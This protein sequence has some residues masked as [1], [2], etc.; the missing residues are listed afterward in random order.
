MLEKE[1]EMRFELD[2]NTGCFNFSGVEIM[3]F[4]DKYPEG[5]QGGVTLIM[6]DK[7]MAQGVD[8]RFEQTPGQWQPIPVCGER[9]IDTDAQSVEVQLHYPNTNA[10]LKGFNPIIYPDLELDYSIIT[11]AIDGGVE[12]IAD[13]KQPLPDS[14][15]GKA[16]LNLEMVPI[17]FMGKCWIMD[18]KEG[19]FPTQPNGPALGL[20]ANFD[21]AGIYQSNIGKADPDKLV[22]YRKE[23]S[24]MVADDLIGAPYA[25]GYNF[26]AIPE[27]QEHSFSVESDTELKL[28]DGRF[29]HN[30]GWFV[31]SS[32]LPTGTTG[33][34]ISWKLYPNLTVPH[35]YKPVVAVSNVGYHPKQTKYAIVELDKRQA[36]QAACLYK[37][38]RTG[39]HPV[40]VLENSAVQD[41]LRYK[42]ARFDFTDI[43]EP[44]MYM[45]EYEGSKSNL[46]RIASDVYDRGVWQPVLE[47]FLPVQMCHMKVSEKYRVWHGL[48]HSDDALMAPVNYNHYDGYVQGPDTLTSFKP[49]EHV[50]GL[51]AGGWHDAGDYDLRIESQSGEVYKLALALEAFNVYYD[52]STID[53][54]NHTVEIHQ[55]DGKNDIQQQIEHGLLTIIGGYNSLGRLYRGIICN[56]IRQYVLLGDASVM[57][58][59]IKGDEDDR[60]VFTEDNP[61]RELTVAAELA[62]ASR[63]MRGYDD[64]LASE[65]LR[66]AR[67]L[68]DITCDTDAMGPKVHAAA[69]L[70]LTTGEDKYRDFILEHISVVEEHPE[71]LCWMAARVIEAVD[72]QEYADRIRAAAA[73]SKDALDEILSSNPYGVTYS[74][75]AWGTGWN[76]QEF[77]VRYYYLYRAFPDIFSS[78]PLTNALNFILGC[79]PGTNTASF[80]SGVGS[81]S[82]TVAYGANRADYSFIPGGVSSGTELIAPDFPE[83]LE[84]PFLWQQSEYVLGGGSSNFMFLV[85]AVQSLF[86]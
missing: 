72:N 57:T 82:H 7:R 21:V 75:R 29:N 26:T 80:A 66:I 5:H 63:A 33:Q 44:G 20:P 78:E 47:Y 31:L 77:S 24:P 13:L 52:T 39:M 50:P 32:E 19:I 73:R 85:L 53:Q 64:N 38:D 27:D 16:C 43:R 56:D 60:W 14:L 70:L 49:L 1:T 37:L 25:V 84:F 71:E 51:D 3:T 79:H 45:V 58:D 15:K 2:K 67:E 65:S 34:V 68:Y 48:C 86:K 4:N 42:Y 23:Y 59:G 17:Y 11:R 83:L 54:V 41:F 74:L 9:I 46:F 35:V 10:H 30:N 62:T 61:R 28:Y 6:N 69:E 40:T 12:I 81:V 76:I 22:K 18:D 36:P 55:P 8:L